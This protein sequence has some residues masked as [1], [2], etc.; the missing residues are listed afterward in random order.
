MQV[1]GEVVD[2]LDLAR[3]SPYLTEHVYRFGVYS[4]HEMGLAPEDY[5]TRLDADFSAPGRRP[6]TSFMD[7]R[8]PSAEQ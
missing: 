5:D 2:P 7:R 3:I 4:A 6:V 1:E 8:M